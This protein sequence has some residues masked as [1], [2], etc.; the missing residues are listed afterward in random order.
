ML[1]YIVPKRKLK[2]AVAVPST[3]QWRA[4]MGVHF[5]SLCSFTS[6]HTGGNIALAVLGREGSVITNQRNALVDTALEIGADYLL[7]IDADMQFPPESLLR[8]LG[9][10]K[11]VV[12]AFYNKR[13][14]PYET[15][16]RLELPEGT[17]Q[18]TAQ[19]IVNK[20]GLLEASQMPGGMVLTDC[21]VYRSLTWPWYFESY[22]RPGDGVETF[23]EMMRDHYP[24]QVPKEVLDEI[25]KNEAFAAWLRHNA[26]LEEESKSSR[27]YTS[28]DYGFSRKVRRYGFKIWCDL[29]L[30]FEMG[31]VGEHTITCKNAATKPKEEETK[32]L[33]RVA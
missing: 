26:K 29:D 23:K 8:L 32:T 31:H 12:G 3:G 30:S 17:S 25:V 15:L 18:E 7:Q 24:T 33:H 14:A 13:V 11:D 5:S 28:E 10:E 4:S 20:G 6:M 9:H 2:V 27:F 16:G 21:N 19:A 1:P 22:H